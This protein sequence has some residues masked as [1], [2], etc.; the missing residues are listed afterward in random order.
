M[1]TRCLRL[2]GGSGVGP[3]GAQLVQVTHGRAAARQGAALIAVDAGEV[4]DEGGRPL[5]RRPGVMKRRLPHESS[6]WIASRAQ[7]LSQGKSIGTA[8]SHSNSPAVFWDEFNAGLLEGQL[9]QC[10]IAVPNLSAL[11]ERPNRDAT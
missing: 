3:S 10:S 7:L 11:F 8:Q 6:R 5:V 9:Q 2:R 1:G 4:G